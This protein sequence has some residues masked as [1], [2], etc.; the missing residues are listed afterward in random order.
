[1]NKR[2]CSFVLVLS[3][4]FIYSVSLFAA[5]GLK[6]G[7]KAPN[8]T[9]DDAF[10]NSYTLSDYIGKDP[11]VIYFYPQAGTPGCTKEACGIRDSLQ[12]F[13][14]K[15]I[16]VFGI[17]V[18]STAA[19]D[20]FISDYHLDFPLLSDADKKVTKEYGVLGD[21]GR[22]KRFT[23]I[24]DKK[25]NIAKIIEVKN[26]STHAEEVLEIASQLK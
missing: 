15:G 16:K 26:I 25:G 3:F 2:T 13:K 7:M 5:D 18:D 10:G 12:N 22:A 24:I 6:E 9:L 4:L 21:N 17:S 20:K 14:A 19:I 1:M 11:V 23:F 8:F